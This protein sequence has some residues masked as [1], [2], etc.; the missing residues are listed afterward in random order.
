MVTNDPVGDFL[1]RV[2][3]AAMAGNKKVSAPAGKEIVAVA[4]ALKKLGFLEKVDKDKKS[5]EVA[6]AFRNKKPR[7]MDL[8]LVSNPG[9]RIYTRELVLK[10]LGRWPG[11]RKVP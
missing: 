8:K 4:Q 9:L 6:I 7:L 3:N 11:F 10:L 1:I 5:L 2:K